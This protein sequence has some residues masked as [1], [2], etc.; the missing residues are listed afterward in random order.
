MVACPPAGR[1]PPVARHRP[2]LGLRRPLAAQHDVAEPTAA[3][4]R[5]LPGGAHRPPRS[6]DS[7]AAD[8]AARHGWH[9]QPQVDRLVRPPQHRILREAS[10]RQP[11]IGWDDQHNASWSSTTARNRG[12]RTSLAGLGRRA[13]RSAAHQPSGP[14]SGGG[15]QCGP[16]PAT[17]LTAPVP[18][19][20]RSPGRS[21]RPQDHGRSLLAP[22]TA[23][24]G[25]PD[26]AA[27]TAPAGRQ[28]KAR[29]DGPRCRV[30][31]RSAAATHPPPPLPH[32]VLLDHRQPHERMTTSRHQT[33]RR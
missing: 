32:L 20:G 3:W 7:A 6:A 21:R 24:P 22:P 17:P 28:H 23:R 30:A 15:R 11:A 1:L 2:I 18:V 27:G 5:R 19:A 26:A 12:W 10:G 33:N 9:E 31:E 29:T 4:G 25:P 13:R 14:G 8:G 16:L